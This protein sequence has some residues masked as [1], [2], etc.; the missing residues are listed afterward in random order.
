M[1]PDAEE[2]RAERRGASTT[3]TSRREAVGMSPEE[4]L[5]FFY[6]KVV[7]TA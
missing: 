7:F 6:D 1:G 3:R 2:Q 5:D 4:I